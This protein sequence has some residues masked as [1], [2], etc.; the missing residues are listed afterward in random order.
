MS[1][2]T[3]IA[4]TH[5][6]VSLVGRIFLGWH[7]VAS[8]SLVHA[9]VSLWYLIPMC[10]F[11]HAI[12]DVRPLEDDVGKPREIKVS[13]GVSVLPCTTIVKRRVNIYGRWRELDPKRG[14][15]GG[16]YLAAVL[17]KYETTLLD[18]NAALWAEVVGWMLAPQ[19]VFTLHFTVLKFFC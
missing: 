5:Y 4:N 17:N 7:L 8:R 2:A 19:W 9:G 1:S 16:G 14:G 13:F 6:H 11:T 18:P 3:V 12:Q 15:G 10:H